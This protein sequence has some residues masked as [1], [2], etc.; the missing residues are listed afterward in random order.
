[1]KLEHIALTIADPDEIKN[2]YE[3]IL[4]FT[5][6]WEF[7]INAELSER[8]FTIPEPASVT[9]LKKNDL[10]LEIFQSSRVTPVGYAHI[11]I[12][13]PDRELIIKKAKAA[14]DVLKEAESN[15]QDLL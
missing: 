3:N 12:R 13:I 8:I 10:A 14:K 9:L 11:C 7:S 6:Q 15:L 2:F 4:G 1:M 5:I